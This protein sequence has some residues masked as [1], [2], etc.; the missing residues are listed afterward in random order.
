MVGNQTVYA[1]W[2]AVAT[3]SITGTWNLANGVL[4]SDLTINVSGLSEATQYEVWA[5]GLGVSS[6][7]NISGAN[8]YFRTMN[9]AFADISQL[10]LKLFDAS[11]NQVGQATMS[12][13]TN[14][15]AGSGTMN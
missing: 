6:R 13:T 15:G 1:K 7:L 11:G 8:N 9:I 4:T 5:N 3:A 14:N 12:G 10:T 2:T